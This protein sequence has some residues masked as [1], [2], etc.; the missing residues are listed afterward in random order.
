MGLTQV[1]T[2][3]V[4]NDAI[5][6]TKIPAN[7]IEAS[8]LADNAVDTNAIANN[9]VTAGKLASGVQT[10]I[11]NNADNRVI[12]GSG[13]ANTLEGESGLT[14]D[15]SNLSV[16]GGLDVSSD[17]SI[18]DTIKH[19][20][21]TNTKIRFPA[22]D[23]IGME[24]N[25]SE[26]LRITPDGVFGTEGNIRLKS[27]T[28]VDHA[29]VQVGGTKDYSAGIPRNQLGVSDGQAYD[30]DFNGGGIA[31]HAKYHANGSYTTMGSVEG[32]KV[33]NS[34]GNYEGALLFRTRVHGSNNAI[35]MRLTNSGLCFGSDTAAANALDDYE[36]GSFTA[37]LPNGG[38]SCTFTTTT[39]KYHK[40]GGVVHVQVSLN[41]IAN[42]AVVDILI[43]G[44]PFT[45]SSNSTSV[46]NVLTN[47]PALTNG[48]CCFIN[49][50]E[51]QIRIRSAFASDGQK[52][53]IFNGYG[54]DFNMTYT[55]N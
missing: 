3:G 16:T 30:T 43:G 23:N 13:S 11:N 1:S 27:S 15:G 24:V 22:A 47:R 39:A 7:Q 35:G 32:I 44:L 21:D 37:T 53:S 9:A 20:G 33:N 51:S 26:L 25:G 28:T 52:G 40:I 12:T 5:T 34:S 45:S 6:K 41:N 17:V 55:I 10:T 14:Y 38:G 42:H 49:D 54:L 19:T 31:F 48:L 50:N 36:E 8:E 29:A 18:A 46:S 4:K 2:D